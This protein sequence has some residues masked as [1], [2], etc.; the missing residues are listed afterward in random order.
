LFAFIGTFTYV[1]FVLVRPP[2]SLGPMQLGFVYVVFLPSIVTTLWAGRAV[3]RYGT[4]PT[5]LA[6]LALAGLGLPLLLLPDLAAVLLSMV[7]VGMGTFFA[8]ATAEQ[9]RQP[10]RDR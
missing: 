3:H 1:N 9:L 8:Q 5:L 7:L 10:S 2:L 6:S 4:R